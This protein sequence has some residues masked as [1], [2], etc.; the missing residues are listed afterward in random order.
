ML[1]GLSHI[2]ITASELD[3]SV[4]FYQDT[5]GFE[6]L[7][8]AERKGEWIDK[9]TGIP[10]FHSRVVYLSIT[11]HRQLEIFGFINP[12]I[13]QREKDEN[14]RVEVCY[15]IIGNRTLEKNVHAEAPQS[16][17]FD[18]GSNLIEDPYRDR[19]AITLTDPD[20]VLIRVLVPNGSNKNSIQSEVPLLPVIVVSDIRKTAN[21]FQNV[22]GLTIDAQGEASGKE[23]MH[24]ALLGAHTGP[25]MKI[26][27][28]RRGKILPAHPWKMQRIGLTHISFGITDIDD[29]YHGRMKKDAHFISPPQSIMIGPHSGGKLVYLLTPDGLTM[30]LIESPLTQQE[31]D[32][33]QQ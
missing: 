16:P 10:G 21:Y 14:I 17:C 7:S 26:I 23:N 22:L 20:G 8:D 5:F 15:A 12:K 2:G 29:F 11:P 19:Q 6:I 3:L 4:N 18:T 30:E 28:P 1:L 27:Q 25:C 33:V 32:C 31:V 24:W 13:V 9:T